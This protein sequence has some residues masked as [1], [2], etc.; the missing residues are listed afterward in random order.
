MEKRKIEKLAGALQKLDNSLHSINTYLYYVNAVFRRDLIFDSEEELLNFF[1]ERTDNYFKHLNEAD[2]IKV[3]LHYGTA[4][5][6]SQIKIG[7]IIGRFQI[8][9]L[10]AGH[11]AIYNTV[12]DKSDEVI[13][14]LGSLGAPPTD[15]N[16]LD[17]AT[18]VLMVQR[19]FPNAIIGGIRNYKV[20]SV[21]SKNVDETIQYLITT[22]LPQGNYEVTLYGS[23]D[24]FIP[25]YSGKYKTEELFECEIQDTSATRVR[26][27]IAQE[28]IDS[29]DFRRGV[30]YSIEN[31][32]PTVFPTVDIA[33]L[34]P[35]KEIVLGRK[36][37]ETEFRLVGGFTDV[38][39]QSFLDAAKR[40]CNEETVPKNTPT[41]AKYDNFEYVTSI[42]VKDHR[43]EGTK[44]GIMT[45]LFKCLLIS[46]VPSPAD[47]IAEVKVVKIKDVHP[48][49]LV[50]EHRALFEQLKDN[51]FKKSIYQ[52]IFG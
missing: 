1:H 47:D 43:Y 51:L 42:K 11:I 32:F 14:L 10:H 19:Q 45:T 38:T 29:E 17:H 33:I 44:D 46:G 31:R 22:E 50:S 13:V 25:H 3:L 21:W 37:N 6:S 24:S 28:P 18:R 39:D 8:D 15:I 26:K 7:V 34:T 9:K 16:P 41:P 48:E 49:H 20:D 4:K 12:S 52:R 30:I 5:A 36:A 23:R 40:E 35:N 27:A 2:L